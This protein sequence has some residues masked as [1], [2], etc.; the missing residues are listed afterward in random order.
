MT[1]LFFSYSHADEALRD[2][3]EVGL[4]PLKR[5]GAI[6]ILHDRQLPSGD[7]RDRG[8]SGYLGKAD[9]I[10][11]LV[12]PDFLASQYCAEVE[13]P[14]AMKRHESG[15]ARVIPIILRPCDWKH[16]PFE[17]LLVLPKDGKPVT[18][19]A[20]ED[21]AFLEI[22]SGI[23]RI[24]QSGTTN[25]D[26]RRGN[27]G[28]PQKP[29]LPPNN[30]S[31]N[32]RIKKIFTDADKARFLKEGFEFIADFIQNSLKDLEQQNGGIGTTFERRATN[33]LAVTISRVGMAQ[34]AC[35]IWMGGISS[36]NG[37]AFSNGS[38]NFGSSLE[39]SGFN[40]SLTVEADGYD[41]FFRALLGSGEKLTTEG[42]AEYY[43]S[44]I[45]AP[46]QR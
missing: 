1:S 23:R 24:V 31:N 27:D 5:E 6:S 29:P 17:K 3:M 30:R 12:S 15:A 42:A 37:I 40:E 13:V 2:R 19:F 36:L 32:L 45:V 20:N 44:R 14:Q 39:S 21:D 22:G 28:A 46:L 25:V 26:Q 8:I 38:Y 34:S 41:L 11:L 18:A 35:R 9:I 4:A 16:A 10:L 7:E 43:W 33:E